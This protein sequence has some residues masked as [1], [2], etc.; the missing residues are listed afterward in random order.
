VL[1]RIDK[2]AVRDLNVMGGCLMPIVN[3]S[4]FEMGPSIGGFI[5]PPTVVVPLPS[6]RLRN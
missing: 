6:L 5:N 2:N 1:R 3:V 4:S